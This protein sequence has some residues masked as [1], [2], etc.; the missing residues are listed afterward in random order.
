MGLRHPPVP[1]PGGY[2]PETHSVFLTAILVD[3]RVHPLPFVSGAARGGTAVE[4]RTIRVV[5]SVR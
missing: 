5:A 2:Q 3:V 1:P 4:P